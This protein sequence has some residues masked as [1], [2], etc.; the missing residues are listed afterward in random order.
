[1][2]SLAEVRGFKLLTSA[3]PEL[4][5]LNRH[6]FTRIYP[7]GTRFASTNYD[8]VPF[9]N[10]GYAQQTFLQLCSRPVFDRP[11]LAARRTGLNS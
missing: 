8:P 9:W 7:K 2:T 5:N 3:A 11:L 4:V 1:M 10:A 6:K